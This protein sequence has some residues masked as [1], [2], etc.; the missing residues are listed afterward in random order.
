MCYMLKVCLSP[1]SVVM[2]ATEVLSTRGKCLSYIEAEKENGSKREMPSRRLGDQRFP[3]Y[4]RPL[5]RD[6]ALLAPLLYNVSP[7]LA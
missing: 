4:F 3:I 5:H 7:S 6:I 2:D 1:R